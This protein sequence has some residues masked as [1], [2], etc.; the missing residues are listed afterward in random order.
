MHFNI[1]SSP[2]IIVKN[3]VTIFFEAESADDL[4][5]GQRRIEKQTE[6]FEERLADIKVPS[7]FKLLRAMHK[8]LQIYTLVPYHAQFLK[9]RFL[10]H[11]LFVCAILLC[12]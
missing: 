2:K 6:E 1:F 10:G 9:F 4:Q 12:F 5:E 8:I 11:F 3:W 7:R